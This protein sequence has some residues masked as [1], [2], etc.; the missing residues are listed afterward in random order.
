MASQSSA[1]R[2]QGFMPQYTGYSY[3]ANE[4]DDPLSQ[5]FWIHNDV[6]A[7]LAQGVVAKLWND[8]AEVV[9]HA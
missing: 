5:E 8:T 7:H 1:I 4:Y 6:R 2:A 9:P 3:T